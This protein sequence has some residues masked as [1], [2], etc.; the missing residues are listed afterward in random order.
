MFHKKSISS[1]VSS[2]FGIREYGVRKHEEDLVII[3]IGQL[4]KFFSQG[5]L[6]DLYLQQAHDVE[7]VSKI[8]SELLLIAIKISSQCLIDF[9]N[10]FKNVFFVFNM[11]FLSLLKN[12]FFYIHFYALHNIWDIFLD[13]L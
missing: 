2:K 8:V 6:L 11:F 3:E 5:R 7:E 13:D 1:K 12:C 10:L 4:I 9:S